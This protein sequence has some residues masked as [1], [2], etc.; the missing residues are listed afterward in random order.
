MNA[1]RIFHEDSK[2]INFKLTDK[3]SKQPFDLSNYEAKFA[4]KANRLDKDDDA[5]IMIDFNNL[6][7]SGVISVSLHP[8]DTNIKIGKYFYALKI[9]NNGGV[10]STVIQDD[11]T[12]T[13]FW[14][15]E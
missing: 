11:L 1:L 13:P 4:I 10:A 2:V 14:D 7:A 5:I 12:I 3:T 15:G 8:S 9:F 6:D